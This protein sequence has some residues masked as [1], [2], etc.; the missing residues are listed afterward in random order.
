VTRKWN[1]SQGKRLRRFIVISLFLSLGIG[2]VVWRFR[3]VNGSAEL[4]VVFS[5]FENVSGG[6]VAVFQVSNTGKRPVT[7][8]GPGAYWPLWSIAWYNGTNWN[9]DYSP[10]MP[11]SETAPIV[12]AP[13]AKAAMPTI[14]PQGLERWIVGAQYSTAPYAPFL[15]RQVRSVGAVEAAV[16]KRMRVAW[17]K[18]ITPFSEPSNIVPPLGADTNRISLSTVPQ[19]SSAA[20][21]T[22]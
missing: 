6:K 14:L 2:F 5:H 22:N 20:A 3:S 13:G 10:S 7:M 8:F 17:S 11:F 15:P 1:K 19:A 12:L 9:Y 21:G 4:K 16:K 18:P